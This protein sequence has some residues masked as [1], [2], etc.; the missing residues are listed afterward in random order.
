M[1]LRATTTAAHLYV[2]PI[3]HIVTRGGPKSFS[4]AVIFLRS[5]SIDDESQ[6]IDSR[7][8]PGCITTTRRCHDHQNRAF[9][10]VDAAQSDHGSK[11]KHSCA[12]LFILCSILSQRRLTCSKTLTEHHLQVCI[13]IMDRINLSTPPYEAV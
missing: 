11:C 2:A 4:Y 5:N 10:M 7:L 13:L 1:S 3:S 12:V 6:A 8:L 9:E